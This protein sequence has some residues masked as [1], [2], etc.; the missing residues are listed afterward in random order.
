MSLRVGSK[1]RICNAKTLIATGYVFGLSSGMLEYCNCIATITMIEAG[2]KYRRD[3]LGID[4]KIYYL[5]IDH[6][7]YCWSNVQLIAI[8]PVEEVNIF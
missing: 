3:V 8:N 2:C 5:D 7:D 6:G 1:V 4:H